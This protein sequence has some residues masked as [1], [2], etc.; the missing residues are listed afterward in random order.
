MNKGEHIVEFKFE[1]MSFRVGLYGALLALG[2]FCMIMSIAVR[3]KTQ[4]M[5]G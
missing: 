1:P 3:A 5:K 4:G 2:L